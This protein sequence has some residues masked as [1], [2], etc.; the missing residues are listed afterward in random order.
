[1]NEFYLIAKILSV[2]KNGYVKVQF[3]PGYSIALDNL[4]FIYLDFWNQ[5]KKIEVEDIIVNKQ[6]FFFKFLNFAD[7]REISVLLD[8]DVFLDNYNFNKIVKSETLGSDII[9]FEVLQNGVLLGK[10]SDYFLSPAN[11][12]IEIKKNTEK[13]LL[14]PFVYTIFE[15]I[16]PENKVL[17]IKADFGID[18]VED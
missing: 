7:D 14:I 17:I 6:S 2:G 5:K 12:V 10:V 13:E 11:P 15:K 4:K 18:E 1:L 3:I 16:D 9:G 8:K